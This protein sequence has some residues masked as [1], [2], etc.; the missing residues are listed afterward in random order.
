MTPK[1]KNP[2]KEQMFEKN[3][4]G[5]LLIMFLAAFLVMA[6][7]E[8]F[9]HLGEES[10]GWFFIHIT[11]YLVVSA[12]LVLSAFFIIRKA[13]LRLFEDVLEEEKAFTDSALDSL[14]DVF[15]VFDLEGRFIRW[16]NTVS[17]VS[18]YTD[19]EISSMRP[20]DFFTKVDRPLVNEAIGRAIE[21]GYATVEAQVA[22]KDEKLIPYE[23]TGSL[24][25][26][27]KG[28]PANDGHTPWIAIAI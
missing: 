28:N 25:E 18:G 6:I 19:E 27:S 15:V 14:K 8:S 11:V 9:H 22:T 5:L 13:Y 10:I 17:R 2:S 3:L 24:L 21:E 12:I 20:T 16:N 1:T 26:D 7:V 23:F 4:K